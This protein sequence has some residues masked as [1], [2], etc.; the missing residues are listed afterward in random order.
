MHNINSQFKYTVD[1]GLQ[2]TKTSFRLRKSA[3]DKVVH[4]LELV[5]IF[6]MGA[7]LAYDIIRN[8][9]VVIDLIILI[10]LCAIEIF[11]LIMPKIIV[12]NQ[13]K[14]LTQLNLD[15]IEYTITEFKKDKCLESYYKQGKMVMQNVCD[16]NKLI[17]YEI[18]QNHI[19]VVFDNF[20]CA[21]FDC[22]TL[23]VSIDEFKQLLDDLISKNKL[24]K[25]KK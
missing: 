22:S 13:K 8:A 11:S 3:K 6:I 9:S 10:A 21:I 14:F 1:L 17:A 18:N 25:G 5:F 12:H 23:N 7:V 4:I 16:L 15:D 19:F 2:A 20:A 24:K